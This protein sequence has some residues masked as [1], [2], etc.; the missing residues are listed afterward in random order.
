MAY[1]SWTNVTQTVWNSN[2]WNGQTVYSIE[3]KYR[4]RQDANAG[5]S[6]VETIYVRCYEH[7]QG[8]GMPDATFHGN[9]GI[10]SSS[11]MAGGTAIMPPASQ[12]NVYA[13]VTSSQLKEIDCNSSGDTSFKLYWKGYCTG[14][15]DSYAPTDS[16]AKYIVVT[17]PHMD[18]N[19][20]I[21]S[22]SNVTLTGNCTVKWKPFSTS[23]K[24]TLTFSMGGHTVTTSKLT[25][26]AAEVSAGVMSYSYSMTLATWAPYILLAKT[27]SCTVTLTTYSGS[28]VIGSTSSKTIK[29][30]VPT[31]AKPTLSQ[32]TLSGSKSF[33]GVSFYITG[34][35][36][37][38]KINTYQTFYSASASKLNVTSVKSGTTEFTKTIDISTNPT[39]TYSIGAFSTAGTRTLK[40]TITDSRGYVSN[41]F[42]LTCDVTEY[43]NPS[44]SARHT[45]KNSTTIN[46]EA[47][48]NVSTVI[49][50]NVAYNN[51]KITI[52]MRNNTTRP[53]GS[54]IDV[55]THT[56]NLTPPGDS[57]AYNDQ[58][59][60]DVSSYVGIAANL[61][62]DV[63]EYYIAVEDQLGKVITSA[64]MITGK[65][66]LTLDHGGTLVHTWVP[67][68]FDE[69]VEF[70]KKV[71]FNES[72]ELSKASNSAYF[73]A[74]RTDIGSSVSLGVGSGG[75][76]RGVYDG[77]S[78]AATNGWI[79]Y[80]DDSH[81]YIPNWKNIGSDSLPIYFDS[82]GKPAAGAS[83]HNQIQSVPVTYTG[84][85]R[86]SGLL[87]GYA[88]NSLART[89]IY[90]IFCG[91]SS[92][93]TLFVPIVEST[94]FTLTK[95]ATNYGFTAAPAA[96]STVAIRFE[97]RAIYG[98]WVDAVG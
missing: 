59:D 43:S 39:G 2:Q 53:S 51:L 42:S 76:N 17:L 72:P 98:D 15:F 16:A 28:T 86:Y 84:G 3:I 57:Y 64:H 26:T 13:E 30:T 8:W 25:P 83:S 92:G 61:E 29:V 52:K 63:V 48:G 31:S 24:Y 67:A 71:T 1:G 36:V 75:V 46:I 85:A 55:Y 89:G 77:T 19:S 87:F 81:T 80:D 88:G 4:Y 14:T 47:I 95:F 78:G 68:K 7:I 82:T 50:N 74:K 45:I 35:A 21:S 54:F 40:F 91:T 96:G 20:V 66:V 10:A 9:L 62:T 73:T 56:I 27:G 60:H 32:V 49:S 38:A 69:V 70:N 12:A 97:F 41:E 93:Y 65:K 11:D 6:Q 5:K 18:R 79:I 22:A 90:F 94:Y 58:H 23:H 33:Q 44:V 37:S 34:Y